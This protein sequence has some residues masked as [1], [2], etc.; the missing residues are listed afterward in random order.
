VNFCACSLCVVGLILTAGAA[1][2]DNYEIQVY[3]A[4]TVAPRSTMIELHSN[5]TVT[6]RK[7][8]EDGLAP[9][10]HAFHE[11]VEITQGFT[12]WFETALYIF[13]SARR[14]S[15]WEWVGD[16]LRPRLRV[17][18]SWHWPVGM[19]LST[20]FG[21]QRRKFAVD[22]WTWEIRPIVDKKLGP[23]YLSFNPTV[24]RSLHGEN[25]KKGWEFS[26]NLKVAYD[27]TRK[28]AAGFEYYGGLGPIGDFD[29]LAE[30]Q[31]QLF[32]SIDLN[33]SPKWEINFGVGIGVTRSTD[34]LL[35]KAILGRR[36]SWRHSRRH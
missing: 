36:F 17:P 10:Q 22:T 25:F 2:Q 3:A 24:D 8:V 28:I 20:E 7:A 33:L 16:H 31:Q 35:I 29:P 12:P 18:E 13:T 1:A 6:G 14:G 27:V 19:S 30:Q 34:H 4:E 11:T 9:T 32:P 23:W 15:G 21:Y 5:Y 26:P